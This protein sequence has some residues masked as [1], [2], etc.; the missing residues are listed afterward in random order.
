M[1]D[2]FPSPHLVQCIGSMKVTVMEFLHYGNIMLHIRVQLI[3]LL[4]V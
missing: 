3:V 4:L 2:L 1:A